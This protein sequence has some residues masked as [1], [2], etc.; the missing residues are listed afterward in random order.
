MLHH[1]LQTRTTSNQTS[2]NSYYCYNQ[3]TTLHM[4]LQIFHIWRRTIVI[5]GTSVD[6][7]VTWSLD[8]SNSTIFDYDVGLSKKT[9]RRCGWH[10]CLWC[11]STKTTVNYN[12][13]SVLTLTYNSWFGVRPKNDG[14]LR[15]SRVITFIYGIYNA[16]HD[17]LVEIS[18][19]FISSFCQRTSH[20]TNST[21]LYLPPRFANPSCANAPIGANT[22]RV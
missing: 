4:R 8:C 3:E 15:C 1:L 12:R 20:T 6:A 10:F 17:D 21:K 16:L 7:Y 19:S 9:S 22:I 11:L 2:K 13:T 18:N 5:Y 14:K